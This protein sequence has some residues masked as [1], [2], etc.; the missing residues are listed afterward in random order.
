M[1]SHCSNN[2]S[3]C[4]A[5]YLQEGKYVTCINFI[6]YF[7]FLRPHLQHMEI[8]RLGVELGL[9]L[10]ACTT[11]TAILNLSHVCNLHHSARQRWILNPLSGARDWTGILMDTSQVRYSWATTPGNSLFYFLFFGCTWGTQKFPGQG[12]NPCHSNDLSHSSDNT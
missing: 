3:Y 8:T 9:Q 12:Q 6:I 5:E 7:V 4:T 11:A 10:Q 2:Y 1:R